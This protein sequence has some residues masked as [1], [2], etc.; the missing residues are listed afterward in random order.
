MFN[1]GILR[2]VGGDESTNA[3]ASR[4][5]VINQGSSPA[6][7]REFIRE[8]VSANALA[9]R[10]VAEDVVADRI[11]YFS[12]QLTERA[13]HHPQLIAASSD[14]DM[15]HTLI[16]AGLGFARSGDEDVAGILIDLLADRAD[17]PPRSLLALVLNDAV[18]VAPR[19]TD[20]EVAALTIHWRLLQ[21]IN[22]AVVSLEALAHFLQTDLVPLIPFLPRGDA[23]YLHLQSL[24]CAVV[25][26]TEVSFDTPWTTT[27]RALFTRG[28][29]DAE[30]PEEL[31]PVLEQVPHL[32]MPC[33]RDGQR[34]QFRAINEDVLKE[35]A[36]G[37]PL[38]PYL[39]QAASLMQSNPLQ[40]AELVDF[41]ASL[42]PEMRT[43]SEM[44]GETPL[45][46]LRL[47][48]VGTAIAHSNWRH[49]TG[50]EAPLS[51]W[52]S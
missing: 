47:S 48:A 30:V 13:E 10:Q 38:E 44:W 9:M 52:I 1:R 8:A 22:N 33:I 43:L 36:V 31:R 5:V 14:P 25:Q 41:L 37:T 50:A 29:S 2:Q 27:Y 32:L 42:A 45:K 4:D 11:N 18:Q 28:F 34:R 16:E 12:D 17:N 39:V 7:V 35:Q 23:S 24:G 20:G 15:Q 6:E 51:T 26:I 40:G 46:S 49:L 19:L 21:T 3:Q